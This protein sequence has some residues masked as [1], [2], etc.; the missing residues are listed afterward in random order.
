MPQHARERDRLTLVVELV[1]DRVHE[2]PAPAERLAMP[3][4]GPPRQGCV[5]VRERHERLPDHGVDPLERSAKRA[6]AAAGD[7]FLVGAPEATRNWSRSAICPQAWPT[8]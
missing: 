5:E 4:G 6:R 3:L 1:G 2:Q 8:S 7:R